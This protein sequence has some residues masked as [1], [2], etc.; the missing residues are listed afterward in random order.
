M[1]FNNSTLKRVL[2][3]LETD[4]LRLG[5][6][7]RITEIVFSVNDTGAMVHVVVERTD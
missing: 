7:S 1:S 6:C 3:L 5:G 4:Y 2:N